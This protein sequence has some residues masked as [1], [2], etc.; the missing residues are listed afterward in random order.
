[1]ER[2]SSLSLGTRART[3]VAA[4]AVG[5]LVLSFALVAAL[6]N[7]PQA[8]AGPGAGGCPASTSGFVASSLVGASFSISANTAT[9]S[10]DSLV[11]R[12]PSGGVPGLIEYCVYV[13]TLPT[14]GSAVA[15]GDNGQV[16]D[17]GSGGGS[18]AFS[19]HDGEPSNIPLN[20]T[21]G[22]LMGSAQW[23][24]AVPSSQ[25]ILLHISDSAECEKL[26]HGNSPSCFVFPSSG[27]TPTPTNT[28]AGQPT[29]TNTPAGQPTPT[30]TPG[31]GPT[32]TPTIPPPQPTPTGTL[33]P[34]K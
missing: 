2:L 28:P 18:F 16:F 34:G 5:F 15:V 32:A 27:E 19:R 24:G 1:M 33:P 25:S 12:S 26:Y 9:Y 30:A 4:I 20:G 29:P 11:N 31:Q 14:S 3:I 6:I 23:S 8:N 7:R 21:T 10:F 13:S 22:I 17:F